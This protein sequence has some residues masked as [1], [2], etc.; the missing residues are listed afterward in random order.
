MGTWSDY[1][2][3]G[4]WGGKDIPDHL[5]EIATIKG[6]L[7]SIG[8]C[9]DQYI[10]ADKPGTYKGI[11]QVMGNPQPT[12]FKFFCKDVSGLRARVQRL[13]DQIKP[14]DKSTVSGTFNAARATGDS[15]RQSGFGIGLHIEVADIT[16]CHLDSHQIVAGSAP[17]V[18]T[19]YNFDA[20]ADH[21]TFDLAPE[22]PILKY[23]YIPLGKSA[24]LGPYFSMKLNRPDPNLH[25]PSGGPDRT[26]EFGAGVSVRGTFGNKK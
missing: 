10:D 20:I 11:M 25:D 1:R 21:F 16:D 13:K 22:L 6:A 17:G 12:G 3:H 26:F 24:S 7:T 5:G 15:F 14:D 2:K 19:I 4:I 18:G 9:I 23:A 8:I